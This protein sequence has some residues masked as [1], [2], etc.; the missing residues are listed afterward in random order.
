MD[1]T[2][3]NGLSM[4]GGDDFT[5]IYEQIDTLNDTV[6][7]KAG[8]QTVTGNKTITGDL[9]VDNAST[10]LVGTAVDINSD[11][12]QLNSANGTLKYAHNA[13]QSTIQNNNIFLADVAGTTGMIIQANTVVL[14]APVAGSITQEVGG[15]NKIVLNNTTSTFDNTTTNIQSGGTTKITTGSSTTTLTNDT[16]DIV[17][18]ASSKVAISGTITT[19]D[20]TTTNI[21]SGG[22]NKI[23]TNA[24]TTT[25]NNTGTTAIQVGGDA[26]LTLQSSTTTLN[27]TATLIN[28]GG[29]FKYSQNAT[30]T[31]I[32]NA[33]LQLQA[34]ALDVK[35]NQTATQTD[36]TNGT[37]TMS[38]TTALRQWAPTM[39]FGY[40]TTFTNICSIM[41]FSSLKYI[42]SG[43]N[44]DGTGD[45]T[46]SIAD[47]TRSY[48]GLNTTRSTLSSPAVVTLEGDTGVELQTPSG[49]IKY[50]Q[51]TS[52]TTLNNTTINL[53]NAGTTRYTQASGTTTLTNTSIN[54]VGNLYTSAYL[55]GTS[56]GSNIRL[57]SMTLPLGVIA[58]PTGSSTPITVNGNWSPSGTSTLMRTP[59]WGNFYPLYAM[60]G[61]DNGTISGGGV[62]TIK[63]RLREETNNYDYTTD[64]FALTSGINTA[65]TG[66]AGDF[67]TFT[68]G[69]NSRISGGV[70]IRAQIVLT[71]T[72]NI[73]ASTKSC[74]F[75]AYG[76]QTR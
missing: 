28:S 68:T 49:T 39:A 2:L 20:N 44:L 62:M 57:A 43:F 25:L 35:Y 61:F 26:K 40:D 10:L 51:S 50:T 7:F 56:G 34:A 58:I 75:T 38:A 42:S 63:I 24:T 45:G 48:F 22:T 5:N 70:L 69:S 27:N 52:A 13:T 18:G 71:R 55:L 14:E 6:V 17:S 76:Y 4:V 66:G 73:S 19:L 72:A 12:L 47:A 23:T 8:T 37:I 67:T 54:A 1:F 29:T 53:Q 65:P 9:V 21:R 41:A 60:I 3:N 15:N 46:Y 64:D 11:A 74:F 31:Q 33:T 59:E 36:I 16:T 30:E 32:R